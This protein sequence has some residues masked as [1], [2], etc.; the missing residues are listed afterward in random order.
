M[1]KEGSKPLDQAELEQRGIQLEAEERLVEARDV[2]AAVLKENPSSQSAVEGLARV[3]IQLRD[4]DAADHCARALAFHDDDPELQLQ[5]IAT[6]AVEL[7]ASVVPMLETFVGKH[8]ESVQAH[9]L[10]ADLRAQAGIG[11][12]FTASYSEALRYHPESRPLLMSYWNML[13][14][15]GRHLEA[16][17]SMDANRALFGGNR[18]FTMLEIAI[19]GHSGQIERSTNLL[20]DLDMRPDAQLA[21][22]LNFLQRNEAGMAVA[23]LASVVLA[24]PDNLEAWALL[25]LAWRITGDRRHQWLVG[26][27]GLFGPRELTLDGGQLEEIA[28]TLRGLHRASAHPIGQSLRGGTQ[29]AGQLFMRNDPQIIT[30]IEALALSIREFFQALPAED[31]KHP[32][33][34]YRNSP[35]AFGPSWSVR[36]TGSG[37]HAAHFHPGGILSSACYICI[38]ESIADKDAQQGWLEIGRP[39][40]EIGLDIPPLATFEP[41]PGRLVLFPSYLFHGTRPFTG[42]ERLT[43]AFDLVAVNRV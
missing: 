1:I 43:V 39:P 9:E 7:G 24:Q 25:E 34:K 3:S 16:I 41:K 11:D 22:G 27:P 26:Q 33:L 28:E 21:R 10:L 2:F 6:A 15:S 8:A 4:E 30:L 36:F 12:G 42:G 14:K 13:S 31:S 38:P 5:M 20:S 32:L 37:H 17:A 23:A 35:I 18:D 29:T 19:A 40:A